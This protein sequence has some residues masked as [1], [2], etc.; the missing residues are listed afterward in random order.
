MADRLRALRARLGAAGEA[1]RQRSFWIALTLATLGVMAVAAAVGSA[2]LLRADAWESRANALRATDG[3]VAV[4]RRE[5]VRSS[6]AE[7]AAWRRS[8]RAVRGRAIAPGDRLALMQLVAQRAEELGIGEVS[9]AF[10]AV[11]T[12]EID[13]VREVDGRVFEPAPYVLQLRFRAAYGQVASF[14]GALPPA[15]DVHRLRTEGD[16]DDALETEL[17]LVVFLAG[18]A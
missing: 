6:P 17:V 8:E 3:A 9:V 13:A 2:A 7:S 18:D 14:I 11:D 16:G 5:L 1:A 10:G 15:V 12:L 4:W